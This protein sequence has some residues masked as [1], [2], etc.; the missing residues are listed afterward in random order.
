MIPP[1]VLPGD[2]FQ[3]FQMPNAAGVAGK[4]VRIA[5]VSG[6]LAQLEWINN[7]ASDIT[8]GTLAA[9]R[10]PATAVQTTG[11]YADPA[12]VTALAASKITGNFPGLT[13]VVAGGSVLLWQNNGYGLISIG[14]G[15]NSLDIINTGN[16]KIAS[17]NTIPVEIHVNGNKQL[18]VND[19]SSVFTSEVVWEPEASTSLSTNGQFTIEKVSNTE[20]RL[21][22]RGSDG[23]SRSTTLTLS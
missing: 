3:R 15:T 13:S 19:G 18:Q 5:S 4:Y 10:L 14:D 23:T 17:S 1:I 8:E 21:K 7:S 11:S 22:L 12:W 6:D 9:A 2:V 20:V 16:W